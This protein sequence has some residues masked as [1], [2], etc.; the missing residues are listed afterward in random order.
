MKKGMTTE[1]TEFHG[2]KVRPPFREIL[3]IPWFDLTENPEE[4]GSALSV[5]LALPVRSFRLNAGRSKHWRSQWHTL[6]GSPQA[7][8]LSV[9]QRVDRNHSQVVDV[10]FP[11]AV[12]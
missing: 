11:W 4:F 5:P 8:S 10:D 9:F 12:E 3:R 2:R 1:D 6:V 7:G